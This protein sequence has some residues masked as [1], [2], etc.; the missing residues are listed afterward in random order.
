MVPQFGIEQADEKVRIHR[1]EMGQV[2]G[3]KLVDFTP[4]R[5]WSRV[6]LS[7]G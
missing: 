6:A 1:E 4:P 7:F 3:V 5:K 2:H